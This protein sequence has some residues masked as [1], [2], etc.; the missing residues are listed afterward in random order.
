[1]VVG[2]LD[3]VGQLLEIGIAN[4]RPVSQL[5]SGQRL[6]RV[7]SFRTEV[8]RKCPVSGGV[9]GTVSILRAKVSWNRSC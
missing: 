8:S 4:R 6:A 1:M 5:R 7:S 3:S 2:V 9:F